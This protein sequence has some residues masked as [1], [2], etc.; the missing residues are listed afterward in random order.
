MTVVSSTAG[1]RGP[2]AKGVVADRGAVTWLGVYLV[3]LFL[4]QRLMLLPSAGFLG[5]QSILAGLGLG[6]L[7]FLA[8]LRRGTW[9]HPDA[10]TTGIGLFVVTLLFS[11]AL[12][13]G[14]TT[15]SEVRG[16]DRTLVSWLCYVA[17]AV[18]VMDCVRRREDIERLGLVL[19]GLAALVALGGVA[20]S[21]VRSFSVHDAIRS[22]GLLSGAPAV[23]DMRDGLRRAVSTSGHPIELAALCAVLVPLA[24]HYTRAGR[25]SVR[26]FAAFAIIMLLAATLGTVSRTGFIA[27]AVGL[28]AY[29]AATGVRFLIRF[30]V[31]ASVLA[32]V[33]VVTD[34]GGIMTTVAG[35]FGSPKDP[36][37]QGRVKDYGQVAEFVTSHP[38]FGRGVGTFIPSRYFVLDNQY[39]GLLVEGGIAALVAFGFLLG[40][41]MAVAARGLRVNRVTD[42]PDIT[43]AFA[44]IV[45]SLATT[46]CFFDLLAFRQVGS[47]LFLAIGAI[48]ALNRDGLTRLDPTVTVAPSLPSVEAAGLGTGR[49]VPAPS[50]VPG[51]V[52]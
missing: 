44:A 10:V 21:L 23:P 49:G 4:P 35:L 39:L 47:I 20:E 25:R 26:I 17:V 34:V 29:A 14:V 40:A 50:A 41:T 32:T 37:I 18:F 7:W 1:G 2:H 28:F 43:A 5:S 51:A 42:A 38:L 19:L 52:S 11:Y 27:L 6:L 15:G 48:A 24:L 31:A 30:L 13:P 46:A 3:V 9:G 16:T 8:R 33:V 45:V 12:A 22:L 36:S